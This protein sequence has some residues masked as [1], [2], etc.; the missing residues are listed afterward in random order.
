MSKLTTS[1][2]ESIEK[3]SDNKKISNNI[4]AARFEPYTTSEDKID[5]TKADPTKN[6]DSLDMKRSAIESNN[7]SSY[8]EPL[9]INSNI[10]KALKALK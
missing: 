3:I 1:S 5:E 7:T 6:T 2:E 10:R 4:E 9:P 8:Y